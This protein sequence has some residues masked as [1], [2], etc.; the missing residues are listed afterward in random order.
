MTSHLSSERIGHWAILPLKE[1]VI[2]NC[3]D[4]IAEFERRAAAV[5]TAE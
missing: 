2:G 3:F 4:E 1:A 5:T